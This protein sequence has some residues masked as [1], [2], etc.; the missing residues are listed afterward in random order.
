MPEMDRDAHGAW[1]LSLCCFHSFSRQ[2]FTD[3]LLCAMRRAE[4]YG[5]SWEQD[6]PTVPKGLLFCGTD[7]Q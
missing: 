7:M 4:Y 1:W 3:H 6:T 5:S 2:I